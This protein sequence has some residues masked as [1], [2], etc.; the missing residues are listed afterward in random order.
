MLSILIPEYNHDCSKLVY[1]LYTQCRD[2]KID[3]EIIVLDD[4]STK[5]MTENKAISGYPCCRFVI[6]TEN[7]GA[8]KSRN[9]L[10]SMASF[11]NILLIDCDAQITDNKYIEKYLENIERSEVIVG[12]VVYDKIMPEKEKI[13]RWYYGRNREYISP[14]VKN[15]QP[16]KSF[17]SFQ[18]LTKKEIMINHPFD[19]SIT[20]YGHEDTLIGY[21][22]SKA[23]ISILHIDNPLIHTGLEDNIIFLE[24]SLVS[25]SKYFTNPVFRQDTLLKSIKIFRVF[26][27]ICR[28]KLDKAGSVLFRI[29]RKTMKSN[30]I[31]SKPSLFIFDCYRLGYMCLYKQTH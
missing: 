11:P 26:D 31:N 21:E 18:F 27:R 29:F 22:L 24:K 1:D 30:L 6:N 15:I 8:A 5:Y 4:A 19:E 3:F 2:L 13:L 23:G 25:A 20:D 16:Y 12:G 10:V 28:L 9:K 14:M 17:S 7:S